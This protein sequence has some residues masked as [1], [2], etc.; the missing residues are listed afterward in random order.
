MG[1]KGLQTIKMQT[2]TLKCQKESNGRI[3]KVKD[4]SNIRGKSLRRDEKS[5]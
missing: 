1:V 3:G 2:L 5:R 4:T